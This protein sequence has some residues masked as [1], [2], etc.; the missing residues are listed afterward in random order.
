MQNDLGTRPTGD[1]WQAAA[2]EADIRNAYRLFLG[3]PVESLAALRS[4]Q[5]M[6]VEEVVVD[7][8][9]S[10]EFIEHI[11]RPVLEHGQ[12]DSWLF[13]GFPRDRL[14]KWAADV[15]PI[16]GAARRM[17]KA[18]TWRQLLVIVFDAPSFKRFLASR[19]HLAHLQQFG[20]CINAAQDLN[21]ARA[22]WEGAS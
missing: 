18:E 6:T 11:E 21:M 9:S 14:L 5:P 12:V 17:P 2:S 1:T 22:P 13:D 3:R 7:L 20:K 15:L 19:A 4:K 8:L 10:P 16:G